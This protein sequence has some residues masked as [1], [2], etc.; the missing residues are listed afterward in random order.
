MIFLDS[1]G[2][3]LITNENLDKKNFFIMEKLSSEV[4]RKN[5]FREFLTFSVV[6]GRV[7][8]IVL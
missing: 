3:Y 2:T 4:E 1:I 5:V 7:S 6:F 8:L